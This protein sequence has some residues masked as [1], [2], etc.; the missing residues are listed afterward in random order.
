MLTLAFIVVGLLLATVQTTLFMPSPVWL[1]APDLYYI[2][3]G[4]LAYHLDVFRSVLIILPISC[5]LDV[6]SGTIIG[7]YPAICY[8]GY[9]LL[10]C[11]VSKMPVR[12]SLYQFPLLTASYL[13]VFWCIVVLLN[14]FQPE[15]EMLWSW[16]PVL[17]RA[18]VLYLCSYPLFRVFAALERSLQRDFSSSIRTKRRHRV[19][20]Q[21][22]QDQEIP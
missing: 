13:V 7:M 1:I 11:I 17:L 8:C 15:A 5:V 18:A 14:L 19:G 4:Y 9:F 21:F 3:I 12:R 16:S 22:R 2:L 20:N 6:Y 10:K